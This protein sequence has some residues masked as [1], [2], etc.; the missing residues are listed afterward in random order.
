MIRKNMCIVRNSATC[1]SR[2]GMVVC[3]LDGED[4]DT[5]RMTSIGSSNGD[6]VIRAGPNQM[7]HLSRNP[8]FM[9]LN[10]LRINGRG[11]HDKT[12]RMFV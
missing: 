10:D 3:S 4:I 12:R 6:I 7:W 8:S 11:E 9:S 1:W 2:L 5:I